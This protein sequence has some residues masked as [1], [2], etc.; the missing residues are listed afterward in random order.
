MADAA[1]NDAVAHVLGRLR[2]AEA[3]AGRPAGSARLVAVTKTVAPERILAAWRAGLRC[4]G[5][6]YVQEALGK[7]DRL[8][9]EAEWHFIGHL[10]SN[11]ARQAV[12]AFALIHS[13]DRPSLAEALEREAR[14]RGIRVGVLLQVNAGDE[15]TKGGATFDGAVELARRAAQWP[16]LRIRGLMA[17][18]PYFDDPEDVRPH[19]RALRELR[20]RIASLELPGVEMDELSLGMSHDFP[21]AVEEGATLVRVGSALFGE[22]PARTA[23]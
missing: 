23:G 3:R 16:S 6:S 20:D 15:E 22:R 1:V 18:P 12:D 7:I 5:E 11:K 21:V 14:K 10:Q 8:P 9:P 17:I 19:F 2:A 4:F 13:V